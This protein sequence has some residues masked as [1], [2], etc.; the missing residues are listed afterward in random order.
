MGPLLTEGGY[1][2]LISDKLDILMQ[3]YVKKLSQDEF[4]SLIM[5]NKIHFEL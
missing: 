5:L 2:F 4:Y 3:S 1:K